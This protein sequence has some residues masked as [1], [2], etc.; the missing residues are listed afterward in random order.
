[1]S[2]MVASFTPTT[3][4]AAVGFRSYAQS[5]DLTCHENAHGPTHDREGPCATS[6]SAMRVRADQLQPLVLPHDSQT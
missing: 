5:N 2:F 1:M 4:L 6:L 3:S